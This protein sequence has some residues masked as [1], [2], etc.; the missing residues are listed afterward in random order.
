MWCSLAGALGREKQRETK[1]KNV[2]IQ[3]MSVKFF[4]SL[5]TD[6]L[7]RIN[8]TGSFSSPERLAQP[9]SPTYRCDSAVDKKS[10]RNLTP[11]I[12]RVVCL[13]VVEAMIIKPKIRFWRYGHSDNPIITVTASSGFWAL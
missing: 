3:M 7:Q 13:D 5:M 2:R 8:A 1:E 12:G 6:I 10:S 4:I 9:T 11:Q